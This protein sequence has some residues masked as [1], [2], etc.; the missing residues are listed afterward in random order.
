MGFLAEKSPQIQT[1]KCSSQSSSQPLK[2]F[3]SLSQEIKPTVLDP[4]TAQIFAEAKG[5]ECEFCPW[6]KFATEFNV[7]KAISICDFET[8]YFKGC[9]K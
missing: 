8:A 5:D 1:K 3:R 9:G 6:G 7:G 4:V 2:L